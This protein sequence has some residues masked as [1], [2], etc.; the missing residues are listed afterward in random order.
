MTQWPNP[1]PTVPLLT[2]DSPVYATSGSGNISL[3][4]LQ[5]YLD[6][7]P[8]PEPPE[9]PPPKPLA[10]RTALW[11]YEL[12]QTTAMQTFMYFAFVVLFQMLVE[13]MRM[14]EEYF[15]DKGLAD[16]FIENHCAR[17]QGRTPALLAHST[18]PTQPSPINP[19]LFIQ[20]A[21]FLRP[22]LLLF[23]TVGSPLP[24]NAT[25]ARLGCTCL[26]S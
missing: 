15:L 5:V 17:A 19:A 13:C 23:Q 25:C 8:P 26:G 4:E 22:R 7:T 6:A 2:L 16:T 14:K 12:I 24:A 21:R 11:V 9:P 20:H 1:T 3:A 18:Q 10:V